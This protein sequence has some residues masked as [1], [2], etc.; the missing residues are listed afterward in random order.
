MMIQFETKNA[1]APDFGEPTARA[2]I[3]SALS[4]LEACL[5]TDTDLQKRLNE[6][7]DENKKNEATI[8]KL[9]EQIHRHQ[10]Q[11][12]SMEAKIIQLSM[13]LAMSKADADRQQLKSSQLEQQPQEDI[14]HTPLRPPS[15]EAY[16]IAPTENLHCNSRPQGHHRSK[17]LTIPTKFAVKM[18][19]E[20]GETM[21]KNNGSNVNLFLSMGRRI[22]HLDSS[23][24]S[25]RQSVLMGSIHSEP[26]EKI[27]SQS[28]SMHKSFQSIVTDGPFDCD[29]ISTIDW[30]DWADA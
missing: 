16:Q 7:L 9:R 8:M 17:S 20:D 25:L 24:R 1:R 29:N 18:V 5:Y 11:E 21:S 4:G 23:F 14:L 30:P 15:K 6:A 10:A 2:D 22:G 12:R 3:T 19:D 28:G 27:K 13:D 26:S